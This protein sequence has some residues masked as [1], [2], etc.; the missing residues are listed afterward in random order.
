MND[1]DGTRRTVDYSADPINGFNA[2][3]RKTP[4]VPSHAVLV[5]E[6]APIAHL[7]TSEVTKSNKAVSELAPV[8]SA[9]AEVAPIPSLVHT[10]SVVRSNTPIAT[11]IIAPIGE[12]LL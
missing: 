9:A 10:S 8:A 7:V 3:V 1:P 2:V 6:T 12:Y 11:H 5:A 4:L